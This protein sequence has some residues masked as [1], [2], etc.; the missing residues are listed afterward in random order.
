[1]SWTVDL[2]RDAKKEFA[3]LPASVQ[4]RVARLLLTLESDPFPSGCK[5]LKN[6]DGWRLRIGD[7]RILY[8]VDKNAKQIIVGVIGS[9]QSV[10]KR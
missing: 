4:R 10:Y 2:A 1:V 3:R 8:F 7:Y 6:R 9:R 5:K